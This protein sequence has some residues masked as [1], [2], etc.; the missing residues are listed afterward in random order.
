MLKAFAQPWPGAPFE[1]IHRTTLNEAEPLLVHSLADACILDAELS[2]VQSAW[3]I[4][5]FRQ[6]TPSMPL[7]VY[8]GTNQREWEEEAYLHGANYVLSK[9]VK[10][11]LLSAL[12]ERLWPTQN[13]PAPAPAHHPAV[14]STELLHR[15]PAFS[16]PQAFSPDLNVLRSFS[17]ILTHSLDAEGLLKQFLLLLREIVSLNRGAIFLRT[18]LP[19]A[20]ALVLR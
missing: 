19:F 2:T 18:P 15:A 17:A 16:S 3:A 20:V 5:K 4:D 7:V 6:L 13:I 1:L 14:P 12:L 9:P 8:T 10:A 11:K